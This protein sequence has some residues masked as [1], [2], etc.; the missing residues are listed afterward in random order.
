VTA[1][2][3]FFDVDGTLVQF[4]TMFSFQDYYYRHAGLLPGLLGAARSARFAERRRRYERT[5]R[6]REDINRMYYRSFR[7]RRPRQ[8][9]DAALRWYARTRAEVEEFYFP[10][11]VDALRRHQEAGDTVVFV[12]GSM[13]DILRPIAAEL[14]VDELLATRVRVVA[15]RYTGDIIPPQTI[16]EG[17][18]TA[19]RAFLAAR[20]ADPADCWAYGDDRSDA[21]ML[22]EVG[23][24]VLVSGDADLCGLAAVYGWRLL[25]PC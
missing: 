16:G 3:A 20:A 25:A 8:V 5:G 15:G 1:R 6:P 19:V 12:S 13:V 7:G 4:K 22:A 14:G 2:Y 21:P 11:V 17:K 10:A 9:A 24:P 23:N 18:A